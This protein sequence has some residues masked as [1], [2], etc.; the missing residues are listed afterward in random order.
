MRNMTEMA[1]RPSFLRKGGVARNLVQLFLMFG[2]IPLGVLALAFFYFSFNKEKLA[3]GE[4]QQE[5]AERIASGISGH[6]ERTKGKIEL[7]AHFYDLMNMDTQKLLNTA[8]EMLDQELDYNVLTIANEEGNVVFKVSRYYTF[9]PTELKSLADDKFLN[10]EY[11]KQTKISKIEISA[12]NKLPEVHITVPIYDLKEHVKGILDVSVNV[13]RMWELISKYRIGK[14]RYAYVVDSQGN[15]L[16][17]QELSSVLSER[18]VKGIEIVKKLLSGE[19]GVFEY[20]GLGGGRVIGAN[21]LIPSTGWGVVVEEPLEKAYKDLYILSVVFFSI[22]LLTVSLALILGLRFSFRSL[23]H[24]L[25]SLQEQAAAFAQGNFDHRINMTRSDELGQ[26]SE[27]LNKMAADLQKTTVSRDLLVKEIEERKLTEK[28]L[29]YRSKFEE[30]VTGISTK[31]IN[32]PID[33]I[34]DGVNH[35]LRAI[36]EFSQVD[37]SYMFRFYESGTKMDNTHEW[38]MPGIEPH[39]HRLKGLSVESFHWSMGQVKKHEVV[40]IPRISSLPPEAGVEKEEFETEGIQSLILVPMVIEG[41]LVG[42]LGFDSVREEKTWSEDDITLLKMVSE[43]FSNALQRMQAMEALRESEEWYRSIF[44]HAPLGIMH[45]DQNGIVHDFNDKFAEIMGAPREKILGF[46]LLEQLRDE[47]FLRAVKDAIGGELGYYEGDYLSVTGGKTS[48]LRAL[49]KRILSEDGSFLGAVGLF[50][51]ITERKRAEEEKERLK[52]Q[53]AQAQKMEA[54]GTLAG[55]IA[56]DFN[57]ILAAIIGYTEMSLTDIPPSSPMRHYLEQVLNSSHRAKDLV[58]QILIFS[59][60][61]QHQERVPVEIAP[62]IKDALKMLRASLPTTIE[63]RQNIEVETSVAL[64][65]PTEIHQVLVNLC[66]NAAHAMEE[67]GG[68]L[69]VSLTEAAIDSRSAGFPPDL[70]PGLYLQLTVSDTGQGMDSATLERIF[71]PYFTTKGVGKGSG[72]G[73]AVVR[74]IIE[75]HQGGIS[76]FSKPG[77]G[78]IFNVYL[79]KIEGK[80]E[81]Q[82]EMDTPVPMGSER[83]LFVDDEKV[84]ADLGQQM[85]EHLGY[86]VLAKTSS[87]EALELFIAQPEHFDLVITDYTMPQMTGADLAKEVMGARADIPVILCTGFTERITEEKAR[88]MGIRA[89]LMKPLNLRDVADAVRNALDKK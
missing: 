28:K 46:N 76:V 51:D 29:E 31:F 27:T 87:V 72:L 68:V 75:R 64:A 54:V 81:P 66:T 10:H 30:L 13:A 85:L 59:R 39:I 71:D 15:L 58:K 22:F 11:A 8:Y 49:C 53:L 20:E 21:A 70:N 5:V 41:G 6:L 50:E 2:I 26:L 84:L 34:D 77:K 62:V 1:S 60:M 9:T 89:F 83:I 61:K 79:P 74:G 19:T 16:A 43:I 45:F 35:A 55:G 40:H 80:A 33:E 82:R 78:A 88:E 24:P 14:D 57:N 7:L 32:L 44:N 18:D 25:R 48:S 38:C 3:I 56:H 42:F 17:Y 63:I 4:L 36:G 69:E 23:I 12:F 67:S 73:L 86:S 65:D 37:R 47:A 52:A